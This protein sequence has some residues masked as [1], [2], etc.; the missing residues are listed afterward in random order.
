MYTLTLASE[1][2]QEFVYNN[3]VE[4]HLGSHYINIGAV[5]TIAVDVKSDIVNRMRFT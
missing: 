3:V 5:D 4:T 2:V 1:T